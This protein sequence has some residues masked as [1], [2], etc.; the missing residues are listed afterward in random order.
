VRLSF[1]ASPVMMADHNS[2]FLNLTHTTTGDTLPP[3]V[4]R[5]RGARPSGSR[6]NR[7]PKEDRMSDIYLKIAEVDGDVTDDNFKKHISVQSLTTGMSNPSS[8]SVGTQ[9]GSAGG[10]GKVI[11]QDVNFQKFCD[12]SSRSSG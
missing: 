2:L 6:G 1:L 5:I 12:K 10:G 4:V 8:V 3:Q 7:G 11:M 9:A